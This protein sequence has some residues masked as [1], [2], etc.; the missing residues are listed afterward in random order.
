MSHWDE[1]PAC[2]QLGIDEPTIYDAIVT[3]AHRQGRETLAV[4]DE[5]FTRY[6]DNG[7][8]EATCQAP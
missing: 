3:R 4:V 1:C 2:V 6:H 7:H 5:F 8:Q